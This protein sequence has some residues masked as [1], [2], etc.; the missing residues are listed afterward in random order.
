M[1]PHLEINSTN[2]TAAGDEAST[3]SGVQSTNFSW[4]FRRR[5]KNPTEVGT[6][7]T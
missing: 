2:P 6:L 1:L 3:G 7:N 5:K 4:A